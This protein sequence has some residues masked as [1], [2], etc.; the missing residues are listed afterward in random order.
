MKAIICDI[1]GTL[2][3]QTARGPYD[4]KHA[5]TDA[6]DP[7][8]SH[9]VN[10]FR[11]HEDDLQIILCT[12][13]EEQYRAVTVA[14]LYTHFKWS[15]GVHYVMFMRHTNDHRND[16]VAKQ[17]MYNDHI[18]GKYDVMFVL[19]D[20]DRVVEMWRENELK[21]LQVGFGDF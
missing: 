8:I 10:M 3:H 15:E 4:H 21:C 7:V 16:K 12:G 18:K 5:D 6:P 14:W 2:A 17:E 9:I 20:R 19:D 1:D 13:R 11:W